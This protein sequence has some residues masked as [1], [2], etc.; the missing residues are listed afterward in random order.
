MVSRAALPNMLGVGNW[1]DY[2]RTMRHLGRQHKETI[3][4]KNSKTTST[5]TVYENIETSLETTVAPGRNLS[6]MSL[7]PTDPWIFFLT[8]SFH[9]N[10]KVMADLI[11]A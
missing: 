5:K 3:R 9:F 7:K 6:G 2:S 4:S 11:M 8:V 1:V 10:K